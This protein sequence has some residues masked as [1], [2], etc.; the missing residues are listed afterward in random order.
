MFAAVL[1]ACAPARAQALFT[2]ETGGRGGSAV[3]LTANGI[4]P[5]GG[6][7]FANFW[8][9]YTRGLHDRVDAFALYGNISALGRTQHYAGVGANTSLARRGRLGVDLSLLTILSA[10]FNRRREGSTAIATVAPI[11][12]RPVKVA[13]LPVTVY[14]GY[15][16]TQPI[17]PQRNR[18][19]PG[20]VYEGPVPPPRIQPGPLPAQPRV[21][22]ALRLSPRPSM[23]ANVLQFHDSEA[24]GGGDR[25]S[26]SP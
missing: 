18:G 23:I 10:P 24:L 3:I 16:L 17:G 19:R 4:R 11:A 22:R 9:A 2:G 12:S 21:R 7:T 13:A 14:G 5:D 25:E 20:G 26:G 15:M 1:Y 6:T 8:G